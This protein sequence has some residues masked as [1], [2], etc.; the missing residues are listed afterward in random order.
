MRIAPTEPAVQFIPT[1]DLTQTV[2]EMLLGTEEARL[3]VAFWGA[4]AVAELGLGEA[5]CRLRIVCNLDMGGTNPAEARRLREL[6]AAEVRSSPTLHAKVWWTPKAVVI[7]SANASANGL[8]F[9]GAEMGAWTEAGVFSTDR[10]LIKAVGVWFETR[11]WPQANPILDT[12]LKRAEILWRRRRQGRPFL[13]R[14]RS[15]LDELLSNPEAFRD[16]GDVVAVYPNSGISPAAARLEA[17]ARAERRD[18]RLEVYEGWDDLGCAGGHVVDF[19]SYRSGRISFRGIWRLVA[20]NHV[21]RDEETSV[22]LCREVSDVEG[23]GVKA[24][25]PRWQELIAQMD[26]DETGQRTLF[27]FA[28]KAARL[29]SEALP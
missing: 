6:P 22:T 25:I 7:G 3:A 19:R 20:E 21:V 28:I 11:V 1:E 23:L 17:E 16:R 14:G 9:E 10:G 29:R 18:D 26:W 13:T 24:D 4:G 12:D 15:L 8:G 2:K 5:R 27:D